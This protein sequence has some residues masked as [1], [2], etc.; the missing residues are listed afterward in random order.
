MRRV[1]YAGILARARPSRRPGLSYPAIEDL[2]LLTL[3]HAACDA[4]LQHERTLDDL[5]HLA[6]SGRPDMR[7]VLDRARQWG[8]TV[9][10]QAWMSRLA[11]ERGVVGLPGSP[12]VRAMV[13]PRLA[14]WLRPIVEPSGIGYFVHQLG[15]HDHPGTV[16][17][18]FVRYAALRV[19]D[20]VSEPAATTD[21]AEDGGTKL[22]MRR[23]LRKLHA[24]KLPRRSA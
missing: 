23:P 20:R 2:L 4:N 21:R 17:R 19:W 18:A 6:T 11:R 16:A 13:G 3:L 5:E 14:D 9:A 8:L 22:G 1:D 7:V 12:G 24:S 15:W 10:V